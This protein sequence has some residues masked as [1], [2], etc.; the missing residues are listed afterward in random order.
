MHIRRHVSYT[1][2]LSLSELN[3]LDDSAHS[4]LHEDSS[5]PRCI[6]GRSTI[7]TVMTTI[8]EMAS[9]VTDD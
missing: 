6:R 9:E 8:V 2:E 4:Y 7:Q 5:C 3:A 1:I